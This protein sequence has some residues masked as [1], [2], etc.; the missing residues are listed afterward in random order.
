MTIKKTAVL[1]SILCLVACAAP[2]GGAAYPPV[3]L[4]GVQVSRD[5]GAPF[6]MD[7]LTA[8]YGGK[9]PFSRI[10]ME[11]ENFGVFGEIVTPDKLTPGSPSATFRVKTGTGRT[12]A[13]TVRFEWRAPMVVATREIARGEII[14]AESLDVRVTT[15]TRRDGRIFAEISRL[16]GK[17]AS[18][19][20]RAGSA[21]SHR[22]VDVVY[23]VERRDPVTVLSRNGFVTAS[24]EG[25]AL[26][27]GD[28]GDLIEVR[29]P[30]YRNDRLA[31]IT[32]R[33]RV[34]LV[35]TQFGQEGV[36]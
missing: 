26:E 36:E 32:G 6:L 22:D 11:P 10:V 5:D 24:L 15:Y 28:R 18:R 9:T 20:I 21:L 14:S 30:R 13:V 23:L 1:L 17:R 3:H 12:R 2:A 16:E 29:I 33:G 34:E 35:G 27:G 8:A 4:E 7:L 19:R 31:V 25:V